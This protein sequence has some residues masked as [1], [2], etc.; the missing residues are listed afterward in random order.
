MY[1]YI[2]I[3]S[4]KESLNNGDQSRRHLCGARAQ[5]LY[6]HI[7]SFDGICNGSLHPP[8][9]VGFGRQTGDAEEDIHISV[10][11]RKH[12]IRTHLNVREYGTLT[13]PLSSLTPHV[14]V[15]PGAGGGWWQYAVGLVEREPFARWR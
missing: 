6:R 2:Y 7:R 15:R 3:Y 11:T 10:G 12:V 4:H 1:I 13:I 9:C 5:H 14:E 8:V